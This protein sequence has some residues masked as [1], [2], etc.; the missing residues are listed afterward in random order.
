M[1]NSRF[2]FL[3]RYKVAITIFVFIS[4]INI[5]IFVTRDIIISADMGY[6]K[7]D[8][9]Y[10][11]PFSNN[12]EINLTFI[13]IWPIMTTIGGLLGIFL[14]PALIWIHKKVFGHNMTYGI[15]EIH[16]SEKFNRSF[17]GFFPSLMAINFSLLLSDYTAIQTLFTTESIRSMGMGVLFTQVV[18]FIVGLTFTL[19]IAFA[20]FSGL[21]ALSDAGIVFSNKKGVE[22][23][24]KEQPIIGQSIGG[25][26]NYL[27]KGYAGI[28]VLVAYYEIIFIYLDVVG[29]SSLPPFIIFVN[30]YLFLGYIIILPLLSIPAII[31]LDILRDRR[32]EFTRKYAAKLGIVDEVTIEFKKINK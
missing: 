28:G 4:I 1:K 20:L 15:E 11:L 22:K 31:I 13:I 27:L 8:L 19:I 2:K 9:A 30:L 16:K 21:W 24:K 7:Q 6:F 14:S 12:L 23:K 17:R 26:Y 10:F 25:W 18:T 5:L 29:G 3:S 32:V